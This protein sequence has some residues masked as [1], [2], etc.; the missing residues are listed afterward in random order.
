[1]QAYVLFSISKNNTMVKRNVVF[2]GQ[3]HRQTEVN[4]RERAKPN[5]ISTQKKNQ[6][7]KFATSDSG[8]T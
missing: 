1:M 3:I 5:H 2:W 6:M 4:T 8:M 7:H